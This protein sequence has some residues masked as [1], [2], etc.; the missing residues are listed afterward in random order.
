MKDIKEDF[1]NQRKFEPD[2]KFDPPTISYPQNQ[3]G[4]MRAPGTQEKADATVPYY[5]RYMATLDEMI[6]EKLKG[7]DGKECWKGYKLS[8]TKKKNGKTVDNCVPMQENKK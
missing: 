2:S 1:Y 4:A 7:I 8:G 6:T 3:T 5:V